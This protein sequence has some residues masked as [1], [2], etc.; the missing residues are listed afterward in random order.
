[1]Q[2]SPSHHTKVVRGSIAPSLILYMCINSTLHTASPCAAE[3]CDYLV[4]LDYITHRIHAQIRPRR[5]GSTRS[6]G[7]LTAVPRI[8]L[9]RKVKRSC[10]HCPTAK[11]DSTYSQRSLW[12][13]IHD[14][15]G[16]CLGKSFLP[17]AAL[18]CRS[19]GSVP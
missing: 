10:G 12:W 14:N 17:A 3:K 9:S 2:V 4:H 6:R 5:N 16:F 1:M 18:A 7:R 8:S 11:G 15:V 13:T 19:P